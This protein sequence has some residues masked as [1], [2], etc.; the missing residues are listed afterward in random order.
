MKKSRKET[1]RNEKILLLSGLLTAVIVITACCFAGSVRIQ[2]ASSVVTY[3]YYTSVKVQRGDTLWSIASD[4]I[5]KDYD[6]INAYIEEVCF[7]N[8]ISGDEIHSGQYITVP[9]Y[10]D[11]IQ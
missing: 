3:K 4:Y 8:K 6:D 5:T 1:V 7:I 10:T 9:Y 11:K 2:A